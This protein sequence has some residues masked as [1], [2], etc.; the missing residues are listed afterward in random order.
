MLKNIQE[1]KVCVPVVLDDAY[2]VF[3]GMLRKLFRETGQYELGQNHREVNH[4]DKEPGAVVDAL[5][6]NNM[7]IIEK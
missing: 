3:R 6:S 5:Q 1:L 7:M 4:F 2:F